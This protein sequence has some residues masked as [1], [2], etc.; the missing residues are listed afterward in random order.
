M[1]NADW[2]PF[3]VRDC[4]IRNHSPPTTMKPKN[5]SRKLSVAPA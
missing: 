1:R 2:R 5:H 4:H 3:H